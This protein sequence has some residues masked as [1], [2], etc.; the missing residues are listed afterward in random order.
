MN[1]RFF[2]YF[3]IVAAVHIFVLIA[4][5][6]MSGWR[7]FF[8]KKPDF[9]VPVEFVVEVPVQPAVS[10]PQAAITEPEKAPEP[11]PKPAPPKPRKKKKIEISKKKVTKQTG[12]AQP[13]KALSEEE[14][15][16]LLAMGAKPS[17]HTSVPDEDGRCLDIVR[18]KLYSA[19]NQPSAEEA[20][21]SSVKVTIAVRADGQ[22]VSRKMI[23]KSGNVV[24]D[25]S[26]MEAVDSVI[27]IQG[28]TPGF[29]SR[30]PSIT[31]SFKVE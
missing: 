30:Y 28:L 26:V 27:K 13:K 17:D 16:K 8:R 7:N 10:K 1:E 22:V 11:V 15:K 5:L 20:G 25:T 31:I 18:R 21:D 6:V 9:S 29:V 12:G 14:I 3:R 24:L 19:W 2:H 4:V 23:G